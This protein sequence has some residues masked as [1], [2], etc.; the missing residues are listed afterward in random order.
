MVAP[1]NEQVDLNLTTDA[2]LRA[3]LT[4]LF[5]A[6]GI[7]PAGNMWAQQTMGRAG[8][9]QFLMDALNIGQG[10]RQQFI[11]QWLGGRWG[12]PQQAG[13]DFS[14]G[15]L[16]GRINQAMGVNDPNDPRYAYWNTG[17]PEADF[18][19]LKAAQA[20]QYGGDAPGM[21]QARQRTLGNW[22]DTAYGGMQQNPNA[23]TNVLDWYYNRQQAP[24]PTVNAPPGTP[25]PGYQAPGGGG[26]YQ[27]PGGGTTT[28]TTPAPGGGGTTT[29][30]TPNVAAWLPSAGRQQFFT[31]VGQG[32]A[33]GEV[34]D[35][36]QWLANQN[37]HI[38]APGRASVD[39]GGGW[40]YIAPQDVAKRGWS[41]ATGAGEGTSGWRLVT[42]R[43]QAAIAR[44]VPYMTALQEA[45]AWI[46]REAARQGVNLNQFGFARIQPGVMTG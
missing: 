18:G 19:R 5:R 36:N 37:R 45:L 25:P 28:P 34:Q 11:Q 9:L 2:G 1:L 43:M 20:L 13:G 42:D 40:A 6:Q 7:N 10:Q 32:N 15:G 16:A 46:Q 30:T 8:E 12:Q 27:Q 3:Y 31:D 33:W 24:P 41:G 44:G 23:S 21:Q 14:R 29:P 39:L 35:W 38:T 17:D 26:G 4:S 22:F